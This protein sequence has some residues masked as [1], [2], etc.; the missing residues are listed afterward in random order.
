LLMCR[1]GLAA[2]QIALAIKN[3]ALEIADLDAIAVSENQVA[4]ASTGQIQR[5]YRTKAA[6]ADD[7]RCGIA[8]QLL[9][10]DAHLAQHDLAAVS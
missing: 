6:N 9:A 5:R 10:V 1:F 4:D 3:L 7:Q 8:Q 2:A